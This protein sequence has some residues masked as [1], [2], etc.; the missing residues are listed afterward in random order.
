[1]RKKT[2]SKSLDQPTKLVCTV[3]NKEFKVS[4]DTKYFI[5]GGYTCSWKCF[6]NE[7]KR[8][9]AERMANGRYKDY[10]KKK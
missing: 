7:V 5:R 4:G 10:K 2:I 8:Q 9:D 6:L 1:M 3:C